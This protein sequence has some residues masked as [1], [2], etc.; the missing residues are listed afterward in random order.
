[1]FKTL[2]GWLKEREKIKHVKQTPFRLYYSIKFLTATVDLWPP[3]RT[4]MLLATLC[5]WL[6]EYGHCS[7][8]SAQ[9]VAIQYAD[10]VRLHSSVPNTEHVHNQNVSAAADD[11]QPHPPLRG[12]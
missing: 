11:T 1:M 4:Q 8:V 5:L 12:R 10:T 3:T 9:C 6:Q 7:L 2:L